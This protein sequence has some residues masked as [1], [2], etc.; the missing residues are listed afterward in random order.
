M[1]E[2]TELSTNFLS[3]RPVAQAVLSNQRS[4]SEQRKETQSLSSEQR[5]EIRREWTRHDTESES[6]TI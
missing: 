4:F 6:K 3:K 5:K 2:H 1:A